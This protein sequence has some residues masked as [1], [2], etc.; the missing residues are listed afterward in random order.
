LTVLSTPAPAVAAVALAAV[1]GLALLAARRDALAP[2]WLVLGEARPSWPPSARLRGGVVAC[3]AAAGAVGAAVI[4]GFRLVVGAAE[5]DAE[6]VA[7]AEMNIWVM[8]AAGIAAAVSVVLLHGARGLAV[9]LVASPV[10]SAIAAAGVL[11]L[12]TALGGDLR[13][14][15]VA[16]V[17]RPGLAL[18]LLGTLLVAPGLLALAGRRDRSVGG[19]ATSL[20]AALLAGLLCLG[21][22]AGRTVLVPASP[23]PELAAPVAVPRPLYGQ[24]VARPLL[25]GRAAT[26]AALNALQAEKPPNNVAADR[27]RSEILPVLTQMR[28]G[29]ESV[30]LDDPVVQA[31]H[32]HAVAGS[33]LHVAGFTLIATALEANNPAL[34]EEG[35]AML[36][37]GNEEWERW[38]A[39]AQNL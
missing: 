1:S 30:Q 4:V 29:A 20:V 15:F 33:R 8:V 24:V 36:A 32:S 22:V 19:A 18:G 25:D 39:G 31:V 14:A 38:A 12:N 34:L 16:S 37:N 10:A 3:G 28:D 27:I 5:T 21:V 26:A 13:W 6:K 17:L 7:R 11:G 2:S 35:N 23:S 9:A